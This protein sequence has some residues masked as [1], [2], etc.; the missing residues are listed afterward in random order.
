MKFVYFP[1]LLATLL[2]KTYRTS[3]EGSAVI[4][5]L[6]DHLGDGD[7]GLAAAC[8]TVQLSVIKLCFY[9]PRR[10][11]LTEFENNLC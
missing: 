5:C 8:A 1:S 11:A 10:R 2:V 4:S 7:E 9:V 3:K 6:E